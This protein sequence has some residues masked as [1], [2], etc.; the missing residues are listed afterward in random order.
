MR[1]VGRGAISIAG[2]EDEPEALATDS[3]IASLCARF[4]LSTGA[5]GRY[6]C[7]SVP[8]PSLPQFGGGKG[9]GGAK[10]AAVLSR[11]HRFLLAPP[12]ALMALLVSCAGASEPKP[13]PKQPDTP[14][15]IAALIRAYPSRDNEMRWAILQK[16]LDGGDAGLRAF[17]KI[18]AAEKD[19]E[20][21]KEM[22]RLLCDKLPAVF[23]S[24]VTEDKFECFERLLELLHEDQFIAAHQY[25]FYWLLRGHLAERIA[26]FAARLN[27]HPENK[28]IAQ[29]P[30]YLHRANGDLAQ[31][32]RAAEKSGDDGLVEG[33][34]YEMAD[35]KALAEHCQSKGIDKL[36]EKS[37][38]RVGRYDIAQR[39]AY[40]AAC[41]RLAGK[42][43]EFDRAVR[44]LLK[45]GQDKDQDKWQA[46]VAAKGLL[47]NDRPAEG[48]ELLRTIP[49]RSVLLFDILC[50]RLEFAAAME[51]AAKTVPNEKG[52]PYLGFAYARQLCLLGDKH[53]EDLFDRYA[54]SIKGGVDPGWV[55]LLM[56]VQSLLKEE[57]RV[58]LQDKAFAHAAKAMSV[59]VP[60]NIR[61]VYQG[62][63]HEC[64][65][66][67]HLFP[68]QST[69]AEV[70]WTVLRLGSRDE[71]TETLLKRLRELVQGS[72]QGRKGVDSSRRGFSANCRSLE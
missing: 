1:W 45:L 18:A 22:D 6:D 41:T 67:E 28:G 24:A 13:T 42:R 25:A 49:N 58:G 48:L 63:W 36:A 65:Y 64:C 70:W 34:L 62:G 52:I 11:A 14:A 56:K 29:T 23:L 66:F 72:G 26:H 37:V 53:G 7:N 16:L 40:Y 19:A 17:L 44:E 10:E 38:S 12:L 31:A 39:W 30:A 27:E 46:F 54:E 3:A 15:E 5:T 69:N 8:H 59:E 60:K 51:W 43:K 32:R 2:E 55:H 57:M 47:L 68:H 4:S 61:Q 20:W 9:G 21:R 33:I 35:W 71:S 50:A